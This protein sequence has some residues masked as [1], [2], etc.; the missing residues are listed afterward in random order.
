MLRWLEVEGREKRR[1]AD[2]VQMG[3]E[4]V[5][6]IRVS[7]LFLGISYKF[8]A[9]RAVEIPAP[10]AESPRQVKSTEEAGAVKPAKP[11]ESRQLADLPAWAI[12]VGKR[13][14][15]HASYSESTTG[16][17]SCYSGTSSV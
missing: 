6:E 16:Y 17:R 8:S 15:R 1:S 13:K 3:T 4:S 14:W 5:Q 11:L 9:Y 12:S 10:T 7:H 2:R